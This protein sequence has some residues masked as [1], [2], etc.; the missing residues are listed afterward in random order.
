MRLTSLVEQQVEAI[1]LDTCDELNR[2]TVQGMYALS[3]S[4]GQ[5]GRSYQHENCARGST[6]F[7]SCTVDPQ[8]QVSAVG[9]GTQARAP[10]PLKCRP[11]R[12]AEDVTGYW[13]ATSGRD[14]GGSPFS[15]AAG[16]TGI[17]GCC[18]WGRGALLTKGICQI[19]KLNYFLGKRGADLGRSTLYPTIDFCK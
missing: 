8:M 9:S 4:C 1:E 5:D 18:W 3:N 6:E 15:N 16:R 2:Q 11:R 14:V 13:D 12:G 10:P 19:G 7:M 17:E